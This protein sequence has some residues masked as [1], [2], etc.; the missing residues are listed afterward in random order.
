MA[1]ISKDTHIQGR[2]KNEYTVVMGLWSFPDKAGQCF[3]LTDG[4]WALC[5]P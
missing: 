5:V 3:S 4:K 1:P 2:L